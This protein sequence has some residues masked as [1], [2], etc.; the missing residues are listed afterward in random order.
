MDSIHSL[1]EE[2]ERLSLKMFVAD[3][4]HDCTVRENVLRLQ[5]R[6]TELVRQLA[7]AIAAITDR[8]S[9]EDCLRLCS[10]AMTE[11]HKEMTVESEKGTKDDCPTISTVSRLHRGA[12]SNV[13]I[14]G[15]F[16]ISPSSMLH[17]EQLNL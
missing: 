12:I 1:L 15:C 14:D 13:L 17:G 6:A 2:S 3:S 4:I 16:I 7:T 11:V 9:V 10:Q 8:A 5:E